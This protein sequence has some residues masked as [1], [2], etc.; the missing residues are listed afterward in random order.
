MDLV[1]A[2]MND[3]TA[4]AASKAMM[5]TTIMISTN[6]NPFFSFFMS[7]FLF[8]LYLQPAVPHTAASGRF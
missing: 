2:F 8:I 3:G 6:V 1:R 5:A 7:Y 4:M